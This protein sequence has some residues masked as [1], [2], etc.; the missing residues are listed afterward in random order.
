VGRE[1]PDE[2]AAITWLRSAPDGIVAESVGGSYSAYGRISTYTGLPTVLGW[3]GHEGQWRDSSLQDSRQQD[4]EILYSTPDW[5]TAQGIV[6]RYAIRYVFV[7]NLE[8]T[9]YRVIEEK[10]GLFMKPVF[11]QGSVTIYEAP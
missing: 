4:I 5:V 10:F 9:T 11:Q 6:N 3:P 8:R 7:G 1:N 2:A